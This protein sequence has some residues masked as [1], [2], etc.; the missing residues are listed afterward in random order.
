MVAAKNQRETEETEGGGEKVKVDTDTCDKEG[1]I[2]EACSIKKVTGCEAEEIEE[3]ATK[4]DKKEVAM[5][6]TV[7][8]VEQ[9]RMESSTT[10]LKISAVV[11]MIQCETGETEGSTED[12]KDKAMAKDGFKEGKAKSRSGQRT[13][14]PPRNESRTRH[15]R[16]R[17]KV[18]RWRQTQTKANQA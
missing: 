2:I 8:A 7:K 6:D 14:W 3:V 15:E 5:D 4:N 18:D 10:I 1:S 17:L 12:A 11:P 9:R 13:I 16:I